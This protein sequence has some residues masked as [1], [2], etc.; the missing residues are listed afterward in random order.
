MATREQTHPDRSTKR[1][2]EQA[3]ARAR[4]QHQGRS[5][6]QQRAARQRRVRLARR[7]PPIEHYGIIGDLQTV[8][9]VGLNGSIDFL[10]LPHFDSPS[11]FARLLDSRIG[12][13]F[14]IAPQLEAPRRKQMYL[15][16][17]NVLLTRYLSDGGVAEIS[18][19]MPIGRS[20][21]PSR[22]V[23]RVKS[24][25][26]DVPIRM[27]CAPGFDYGKQRAK[28]TVNGCEALL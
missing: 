20:E 24:V 12:G 6:D 14:V 9:L 11:V 22:I 28:I 3:A 7:Y 18:D 1:D 21:E 15:P 27:R 23:R 2:D 25:R 8:A 4:E 10:C 17:T 16:D 5:A 19:F 26:G 13:H